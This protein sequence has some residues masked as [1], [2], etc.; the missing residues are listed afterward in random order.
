[1]SEPTA[2]DATDQH[3]DDIGTYVAGLDADAHRRIEAAGESIDLAMLLYEARI[4]R[5]LSQAEAARRAGLHQQAVS[6]MERAGGNPQINRVFDY[7]DSLGFAL[8]L[9]T[10]DRETR[11]PALTAVLSRS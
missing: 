8:E 2:R 5:G 4:A 1:M 3:L 10:L 9:R 7:L 11:E 6:R